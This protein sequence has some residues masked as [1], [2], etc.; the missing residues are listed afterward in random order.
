[1]D[2]VELRNGDNDPN[3]DLQVNVIAYHFYSVGYNGVTEA[4]K[5][6]AQ[7]DDL[8]QRYGRPIWITEFAGTSFSANNPIHNTAERQAFNQVFLETLIPQ[9]DARPYLER[10]AWWQFGGVGVGPQ[11]TA[12][13]SVSG[14]VYTP[15]IIGEEYFRTTLAPGQ[16]YDFATRDFRPTYI[17]Y[18]KG[19]NLANNGPSLPTTLNSIDVMEGTTIMSGTGDFGFED[20]TDAFVRVRSG[21]TLRKQGGNKVTMPSL[22]IFNDGTMLIEDGT[23]LLEAGTELTGAGSLQVN[24][25]GT[26]AT[27]G[28]VT[29]DA[30]RLT[31]PSITLSQGTLQV[32][33]GVTRLPEDLNLVGTSEIRTDGNLVLSG[34]TSGAGSIQ[35]TGNGT[36]FLNGDGLHA[37]GATVTEGTLIVANSSAS[38]TG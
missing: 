14:G 7:I 17:H 38:P 12:L 27:S 22:T 9:F 13:S 37:G 15:T 6:I 3:N 4:N 1:M 11:Y 10:V 29:D 32:D 25:G 18:L 23:L 20:D 26:L 31:L 2:E 8:Y 33:D 36:L 19:S 5:L 24:S 28:G 16:T 30:V 35:S 21:A 34:Q